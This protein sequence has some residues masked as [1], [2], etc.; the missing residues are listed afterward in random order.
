MG[1]GARAR[2]GGA[3]PVPERRGQEARA[4]AGSQ[5]ASRVPF[6]PTAARPADGIGRAAPLRPSVASPSQTQ[7]TAED[8]H[9]GNPI[10]LAKSAQAVARPAKREVRVAARGAARN[11]AASRWRLTAAAVATCCRCVLASPR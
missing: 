6:A 9:E 5:Q 10:L 8:Y 4:G 1:D 2:A 3:P 11:Q 7:S